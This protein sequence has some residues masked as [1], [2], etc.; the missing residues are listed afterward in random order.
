MPEKPSLLGVVLEC[1]DPAALAEFY[2]Q[3]LGWTILQK[4]ADWYSIGPDRDWRPRLAFQLAPEFAPP[5]WPDPA[6]SMQVHLDFK[7]EN[8]ETAQQAALQIGATKFQEQPSPSDFIV[9]ADP[10]GHVFCLCVE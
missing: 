4:D 8:L 3:L 7:V 9:M 6:S 5:R 1:P 10:V 2:C